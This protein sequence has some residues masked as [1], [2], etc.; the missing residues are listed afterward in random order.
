M[1]RVTSAANRLLFSVCVAGCGSTSMDHF[2]APTGAEAGD[3]S[4]SADGGGGTAGH[5]AGAG[6]TDDAGTVGTAEAGAAEAGA[7]EAGAPDAGAGGETANGGS[8]SLFNGVNFAGWDRYLGKP[9]SKPE[10]PEPALGID[11]DPRGVYSI[12]MLDGEPAIRISGEIWGSLIT[13]REFCNFR[14]RAQFKWGTAVW[15]I[16]DSGIMF[17]SSGPLGSVQAGGNDL[18][19]PIGSGS[20]MVASEYQIAPGQIGKLYNLGPIAFSTTVDSP[21]PEP[22]PE[23]WNEVEISLQDDEASLSLD[24]HEVSRATDFVLNWPGE[25]PAPLRCGKLQLQSEGA[26]IFFRHLEIEELL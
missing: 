21:G 26:E 7:A 22:E 13:K 14:L 8:Y 20:F 1:A 3:A 5:A 17:L 23:T 12:V 11:N 16:K 10:D 2:A 24:G 15:T 18:T 9:S 25:A 6:H 19:N 4:M